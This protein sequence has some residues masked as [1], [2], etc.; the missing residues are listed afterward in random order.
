M[1][2]ER[3]HELQHNALLDWLMETG[4][5][6]KPH[7]NAIL[8]GI[9]VVMVGFAAYKWMSIQSS[10][11]EAM[12]WNAVYLAL[13]QNDT[14]YDCGPMGGSGGRR[15]PAQCGVRGSFHDQGDRHRSI[16]ESAGKV[17]GCAEKVPQ[18]GHSRAGHFWSGKDL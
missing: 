12:A 2:S 14:E 18:A 11:N 8:L 15:P 5:T 4:K 13:N 1:K 16:P 6:I 3:R 17:H 9:A 7:T 10:G